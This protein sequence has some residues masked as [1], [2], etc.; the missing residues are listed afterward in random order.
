[1]FFLA[2]AL[3]PQVMK[4]AQE[5][6][7]RVVGKGELP[8]FSHKHNLPYIDALVKEILRWSPPLPLA[9]PARAMQDDVYRGYVI[10]AGATV[11]Q[12]VW[13]IFRDPTIYPDPEAFNPDRFLKDGKINP[14]VLDPEGRAFGAGRR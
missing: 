4:K 3:N 7:D 12:N 5:E 9:V 10:P 13:A 1:M 2:M 6:L 11:I 14:L 8:D